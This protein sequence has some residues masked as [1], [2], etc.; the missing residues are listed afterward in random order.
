MYFFQIENKYLWILKLRFRKETDELPDPFL[1]RYVEAC[2]L[3]S[4]IDLH[5]KTF[6]VSLFPCPQGTD[7]KQLI[8]F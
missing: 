7:T 1:G 5:E 8:W 4:L 3:S 2:I 6:A